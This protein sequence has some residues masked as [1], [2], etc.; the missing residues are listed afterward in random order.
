[1]HAYL[2]ELYVAP[3]DRGQG[4]GRALLDLAMETARAN[5]AIIIELGTS[6]DDVA[7]RGLYENPGF[8]NREGGPDG[9]VMYVYERDLSPTRA[10]YFPF[11]CP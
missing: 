3:P 2:E 5:A 1:M 7:A 8:I 6:E 10:G 4:L 9:P 11:S